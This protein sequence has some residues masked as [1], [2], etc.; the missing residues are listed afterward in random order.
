MKKKRKSSVEGHIS[1]HPGG[2]E[3][4][5]AGRA[6]EGVDEVQT[7]EDLHAEV[8]RQCGVLYDMFPNMKKRPPKH[9]TDTSDGL[10]P[11]GGQGLIVGRFDPSTIDPSS[12][13]TA[14]EA[15]IPSQHGAKDEG[16]RSTAQR[17][18][19][20]KPAEREEDGKDYERSQRKKKNKTIASEMPTSTSDSLAQEGAGQHTPAR[21]VEMRSGFADLFKRKTKDNSN[22][23]PEVEPTKAPARRME[24]DN[25]FADLFNRKVSDENRTAEVGPTKDD[26]VTSADAQ[27]SW[28]SSL[29][30]HSAVTTGARLP[31]SG[32][33]GQ[34]GEPESESAVDVAAVLDQYRGKPLPIPPF[35][36]TESLEET[37]REFQR[38]RPGLLDLFKRS[39]R[40]A[41]R[42]QQQRNGASA[43]RQQLRANQTL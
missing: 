15:T 14:S 6:N 37:E 11:P 29:E 10:R 39:S 25:R 16:D 28:L 18:R 40:D 43:R 21:K 3:S 24:M 32:A 20:M 22:E 4:D 38:R 9:T 2:S 31:Q 26:H 7:S 8:D 1:S 12:S 13:N 17:Q 30:T 27:L 36:R 33:A 34:L 42:Q 41:R 19:K 35:W 5:G 23:A